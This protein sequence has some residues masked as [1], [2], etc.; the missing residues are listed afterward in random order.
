MPDAKDE[1]VPALEVAQGLLEGA[2]RRVARAGV[3]DL[4]AGVIRRAEH[5]WRPDLLAGGGG[6]TPEGDDAGRG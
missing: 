4:A 3:H 2:P 5:E 1:R 6:F